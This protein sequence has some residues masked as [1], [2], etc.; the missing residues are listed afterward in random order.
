MMRSNKGSDMSYN[1][2]IFTD[3]KHKLIV[4]FAVTNDT[5]DQKQLS[6]MV[7]KAKNILDVDSIAATADRGFHNES[8]IEKCEQQNINCYIPKPK[9]T[10]SK[11]TS[12]LFTKE[13]FHYD[14]QHD[15]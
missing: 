9:P 8:E 3:A 4:D 12:K 6:N 1:V 5:N 13:D 15:C 11:S 14:A 7:I 2:Q 10:S